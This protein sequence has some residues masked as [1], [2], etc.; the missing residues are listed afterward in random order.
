MEVS[1][2]ITITFNRTPILLSNIVIIDVIHLLRQAAI[3]NNID[4]HPFVITDSENH[5]DHSFTYFRAIGHIIH[6]HFNTAITIVV[7]AAV[8]KVKLTA[9]HIVIG[10]YFRTHF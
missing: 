10:H 9:Y 8:I 6:F 1:N 3:I 2:I 5:S 4:Y 7:V